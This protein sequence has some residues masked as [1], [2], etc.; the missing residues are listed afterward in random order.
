MLLS[1]WSKTVKQN[2]CSSTAHWFFESA[3]RYLGKN[4]LLSVDICFEL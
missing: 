3:I 1:N 4:V 2:D